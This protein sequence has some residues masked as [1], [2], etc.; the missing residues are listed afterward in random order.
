MKIHRNYIEIEAAGLLRWWST[1]LGLE[2][3][4]KAAAFFPFILTTKIPAELKQVIINHELIHFAQQKE[5]LLV[6]GWIL[7]I[8]EGVYWRIIQQKSAKQ[9]YLLR[10]VEQEAYANMFNL[11]YLEQRPMYTHLKEYF[12]HKPVTSTLSEKVL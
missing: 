4:S 7:W 6:G 10:C 1:L 5:M 12:R 9:T 8:F 11:N 3:K 2:G